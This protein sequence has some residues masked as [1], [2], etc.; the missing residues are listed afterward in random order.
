MGTFRRNW[1]NSRQSLRKSRGDLFALRKLLAFQ[2]SKKLFQK[3][4]QSEF[5][6][7]KRLLSAA[8]AS[9]HVG[10]FSRPSSKWLFLSLAEITRWA[11]PL[12]PDIFKISEEHKNINQTPELHQLL[13]SDSQ[14]VNFREIWLVLHKRK[15]NNPFSEFC[16]FE[17]REFFCGQGSVKLIRT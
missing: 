7:R 6:S 13:L 4:L 2:K 15:L 1:T 11:F 5:G 16:L 9:R 12:F 8:S 3:F 10:V 14:H 17:F